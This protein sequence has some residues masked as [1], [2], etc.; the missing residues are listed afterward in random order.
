MA[1]FPLLTSLEEPL[2]LEALGLEV[3]GIEVGL[4]KDQVDLLEEDLG[5]ATNPKEGAF[6]R[7]AEEA[8]PDLVDLAMEVEVRITQEQASLVQA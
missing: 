7:M 2:V 3:P 8:N 5:E 1:S 6:R 4:L